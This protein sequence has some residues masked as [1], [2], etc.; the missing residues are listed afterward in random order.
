[1]DTP[2]V[3]K[4]NRPF[5]RGVLTGCVAM[6]LFSVALF[7]G[8]CIKLA[9]ADTLVVECVG[10]NFV[11]GI[12]KQ[13]CAPPTDGGGGGGGGTPPTDPFANCP[14]GYA[15]KDPGWNL[16]WRIQY[17]PWQ[18]YVFVLKMP[19]ALTQ[20][21]QTYSPGFDVFPAYG[22]GSSYQ[23][24]ISETPCD[25]TS[26]KLVNYVTSQGKPTSSKLTFTSFSSTFSLY[27][28]PKTSATF[29]NLELGKTYYL[30]VKAN[31]DCGQSQGYGT[32][33][34]VISRLIKPK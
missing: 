28:A 29:G 25:F 22:T 34:Q 1:M 7:F 31:S 33:G 32:C 2:N 15:K 30:N 27:Y 9:K 19:D 16:D 23:Y 4:N 13:T 5:W 12:G 20:G 18:T 6:I 3:V 14:A 11:A 26:D 24:A 8:G 21:A 17:Q 10:A